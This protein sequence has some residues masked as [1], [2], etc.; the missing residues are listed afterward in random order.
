MAS[1]RRRAGRRPSCSPTLTADVRDAA[2]VAFRV[3]VLLGEQPDESA[4]LGA[5]ERLLGADDFRT[6]KVAGKGT[7][8]RLAKEV[9]ATG[10]PTSSTPA[11]S[12][13]WP[14]HQA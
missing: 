4:D 6:A 3:L 8:R 1:S 14:S 2:G 7:G 13:P 12:S 10:A 5:E 9:F 11:T